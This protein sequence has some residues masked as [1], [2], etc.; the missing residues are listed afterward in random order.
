MLILNSAALFAL[1]ASVQA[2]VIPE[3]SP[4]GVYAVIRDAA[5]VNKHF[6]LT[7]AKSA[8]EARDPSQELD[9]RFIGENWCGAYYRHQL[10]E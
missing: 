3:G 9:S 4:D 1:V 10:L 7:S 8:I 5:G 6:K 2:F